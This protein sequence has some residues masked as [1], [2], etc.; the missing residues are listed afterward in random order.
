MHATNKLSTFHYHIFLSVHMYKY[1]KRST[2][3]QIAML[4]ENISM[5][6]KKHSKRQTKIKLLWM[7]LLLEELLKVV[8]KKS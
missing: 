4:S 5:H 3:V 6:H 1:T 2:C 8:E 7:G